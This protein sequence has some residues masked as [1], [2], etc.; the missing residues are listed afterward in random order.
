MPFAYTHFMIAVDF[1][2]GPTYSLVIA[3]DSGSEDTN[4]LIHT[5]SNEYIP[6]KVFIHRK[7]EQEFPDIDTYS[8]FVE[9]FIKL[10]NRATAYVCINKTC[11]PPIS[12]KEKVLKYL[13]AEWKG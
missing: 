12:D 13:N 10:E 5:F 2:I 1:A 9:F 6:N 8:N 7:T 11:K 3:G 4:E